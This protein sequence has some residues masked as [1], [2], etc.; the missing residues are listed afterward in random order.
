[1][2]TVSFT[3]AIVYFFSLSLFD[4]ISSNDRR[5]PSFIARLMACSGGVLLSLFFLL[6]AHV[7]TEGLLPVLAVSEALILGVPCSY[8]SA[9]STLGYSSAFLG[10]CLVLAAFDF[11]PGWMAMRPI[12][13]AGSMLVISA[14]LFSVGILIHFA[15]GR[16]GN[17]ALLMDEDALWHGLE[18][19]SRLVHGLIFLSLLSFGCA[20]SAHSSES[21][22]SLLFP[23]F[24][25][26]H[27][28]LL[29]LASKSAHSCLVPIRLEEEIRLLRRES[30]C[31]NSADPAGDS[32]LKVLYSR[33]VAYMEKEQP[34]LDPEFSM[35]QMA[36]D[37]YSN[38][39]YLSK[40]INTNSGKNFRQFVNYYRIEYAK[41]L[42]RKDPRLRINE[43]SDMSGF[44]SVV[45]FNMAFKLNTGLTPSEWLHINL[46]S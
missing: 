12:R 24:L 27:F 9:K 14:V 29:F 22:A 8:G 18:L 43:A 26:V 10:C 23:L 2:K 15:L 11:L 41:T 19:C 13:F 46:F 40:A 32:R 36:R 3:I 21:L 33:I 37:L 7:G 28:L 30:G 5:S 44:H 16:F 42:F 38:K 17:P 31:G 25:S 1:M 6:S 35:Q 45:S 20:C 4:L 39:L 34:F